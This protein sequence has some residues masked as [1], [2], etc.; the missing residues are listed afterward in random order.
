MVM[1]DDIWKVPG[2]LPSAPL[3][4][5]KIALFA[6][7]AQVEIYGFQAPILVV[8]RKVRSRCAFLATSDRR[9]FGTN[10]KAASIN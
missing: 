5:F 8:V 9:A 7:E 4:I 1:P 2:R 6:I 3:C 10:R